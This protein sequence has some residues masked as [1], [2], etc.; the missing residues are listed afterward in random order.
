M[1]EIIERSEFT[2]YFFACSRLPQSRFGNA[3]PSGEVCYPRLP[4]Y[5]S[6]YQRALCH[7]RFYRRP[8]LSLIEVTACAASF[9][10]QY[11]SVLV[12]LTAPNMDVFEPAT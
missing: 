1:T 9:V 4:H 5:V 11:L 10:G 3:P 12:T 2:L 7:T 6:V 8:L